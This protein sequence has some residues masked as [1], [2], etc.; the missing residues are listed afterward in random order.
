MFVSVAFKFQHGRGLSVPLVSGHLCEGLLQLLGDG[1][2]LL[3]L[4]HQLILQP[5]HLTQSSWDI[6]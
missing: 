6:F 5:V 4:A 1:L 3:L 2:V